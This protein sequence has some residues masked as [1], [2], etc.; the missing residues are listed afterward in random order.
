M[1]EIEFWGKRKDND[2]LEKA[3]SNIPDDAKFKRYLALIILTLFFLINACKMGADDTTEQ[4]YEYDMI[5]YTVSSA[6]WAKCEAQMEVYGDGDITKEMLDD[7]E[8]WIALHT[9]AQIFPT[10][11]KIKIELTDKFLQLTSLSREEIT[12]IFQQVDAIG[13][14]IV[15]LKMQG[16]G[17]MDIV[18]IEK[19]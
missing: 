15:I 6:D 12:E 19:L 10:R 11:G 5:E 2:E 1:R 7:F 14:Y 18:F 16:G 8:Q 9:T 13:K 17:D 4:T 3:A